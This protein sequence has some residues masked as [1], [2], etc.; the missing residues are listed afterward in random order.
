MILLVEDNHEDAALIVR[1]LQK[2]TSED[3]IRHVTD[4]AGALDFVDRWDGE[5]LQLILLDLPLPSVDEGLKLLERLRK[6]DSTR[7]VPLVVLSESS[8][9]D[10]V[11]ASYDR[12]ANSV[13][14][15]SDR[16]E[17]FAETI[18]QI[19]PYWLKLNHPYIRPGV[20][21]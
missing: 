21:R 18:S 17:A 16:G 4:A 1:A 7:H 19:T 3:S 6:T 9:P 14:S 12:G 15:K 5:A 13:V 20:K 8:D 10:E 11:A 2:Q